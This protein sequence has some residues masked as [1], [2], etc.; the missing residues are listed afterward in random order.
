MI[1]IP[2]KPEKA[3]HAAWSFAPDGSAVVKDTDQSI[4]YPLN[5]VGALIWDLVDGEHDVDAIAA[6]VTR[7]YD[8]SLEDVL[9]D[10]REF[11][12]HLTELDLIRDRKEVKSP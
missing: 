11:L 5:E 10:V 7:E 1:K 6:A 4:F 9:V 2:E 3:A 8:V 12:G